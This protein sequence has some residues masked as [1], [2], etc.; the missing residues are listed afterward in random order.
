MWFADFVCLHAAYGFLIYDC[1]ACGLG[2]ACSTCGCSWLGLERSC[3]LCLCVGGFWT[4]VSGDL[5]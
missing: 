5:C 2:I 3:V 4:G 1:V